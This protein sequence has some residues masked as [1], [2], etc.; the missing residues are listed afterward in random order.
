MITIVCIIY[1][2]VYIHP[3][4]LGKGTV[5]DFILFQDKMYLVG[6]CPI[7]ITE[8]KKIFNN[9]ASQ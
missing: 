2:N 7:A 8:F 6:V 1:C 3:W 5:L 4:A 9:K